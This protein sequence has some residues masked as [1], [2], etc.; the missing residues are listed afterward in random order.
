ML[1]RYQKIPA[2]VFKVWLSLK[3]KPIIGKGG[4]GILETLKKTKSISK[5][6][7]NLGMSYKYVWDYFSEIE[8][9]LGF[10]VIKTRRGGE[11]GGGGAELTRDGNDLLKQY[12]KIEKYITNILKDEGYWEAIGLKLS[13]RNRLK[14]VVKDV[15]NGIVT[16]RIKIKINTPIMITAVITR[17]AADDL[18]I[19][20]GDKVEAIVKA[21]EVMIAK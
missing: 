17:E 6:A 7:E 15:D 12:Y 18:K 19:Q 10:P 20:V 5:T 3:G 13:A 9:G 2:P 4:A 8:K 16:S 21:T 11:K 1:H 14:G